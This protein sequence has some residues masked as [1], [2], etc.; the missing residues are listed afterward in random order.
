MPASTKAQWAQLKVGVMAMVALSLLAVLIILM[1]GTNPIF[2]TYSE[3]YTFLDDSNAM[4]EGAT[5]VRLNGILIGKV[6]KVELSGSADPGRVVRIT[7]SIDNNDMARVPVDSTVTLSQQ[8]LLGTK[9]VNISKGRSSQTIQAGAELRSA[10][11][12]EIQDLVR[13]GS[14]TLA[15]MENIVK[16]AD[17]IIG[18]IEAGK[19]TIGKLLVDETLY[20]KFLAIVDEVHKLTVT[21]NNSEG[22]LGKIIHDD[23][24]YTEF[25]GTA[26]RMNSLLDGLDRGEGTA[27]KLLKDPAAYND[28]RAAIAD[29]RQTIAEGQKLMAGLNAGEGTAGKLL[30]SDELHDQLKTSLEKVNALLD[31]IS[32]GNGTISALLNDP[33]L[34]QDLDSTTRE[35][36]GLVKDFRTNP[37]RFLSG[38]VKIF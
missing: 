17:G 33:A 34:Y 37:K 22:T 2:R 38:I 24:L 12:P 6:K 19:G 36:Q 15:A 29:L 35:M 14:S 3:V 8:N 5:P 11:T 20:N 13:Q 10:D 32:N 26:T 25:K 28:L 30:K 16:R 31:K 18:S 1:T 7:L 9:F 21:L 23:T 4:A 27:G